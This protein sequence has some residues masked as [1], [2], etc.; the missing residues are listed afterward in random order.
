[1]ASKKLL[2]RLSFSLIYNI[3][4]SRTIAQRLRGVALERNVKV[5]VSLSMVSAFILGIFE[6]LFPLY[7]NYR[8]VSLVSMGLIL[9]ISTLE[10]IS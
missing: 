3:P 2:I 1:M 4:K 9:S 7:L 8:G 5:L 6:L 10:L